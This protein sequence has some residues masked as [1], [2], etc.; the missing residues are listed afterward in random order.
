MSKSNKTVIITGSG[1]GIGQSVARKFAKQG[2][3]VIIMGRRKEPLIETSQIL[4]NIVKEGGYNSIVKYYSGIDVANEDDI[5]NMFEQ[6]KT[7]FDRCS[8]K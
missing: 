1:T 6:I 4:N 8:G 5:N 7:D 3:N 2:Y